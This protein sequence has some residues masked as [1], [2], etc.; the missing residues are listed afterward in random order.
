V[1]KRPGYIAISRDI[2]EH[3]L[4]KGNKPFSRLEAW[5]WLINA[6]AW[7]PQG[8]RWRF[9]ILHIERGELAASVRD[10]ANH[11]SWPKSN[12]HRFL[13]LLARESMIALTDC[14]SGTRTGTRTGTITQRAPA[15]IT[16]CNYEKFQKLASDRKRRVGHEPG[17]EPGHERQQA[18]PIPGLSASEPTNQITNSQESRSSDKARRDQKPNHGAKGRGMVWLDHGTSEWNVYANDY[19]EVRGAEKLPESR[20]GG[21]GNW[22]RLLGEQRKR[23]A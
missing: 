12:V 5:E 8:H 15:I 21:R 19:R 16:I 20:I 7:K 22:F 23:Q 3:P 9:G 6:A 1:S 10:L 4:F 11:W 2:F 17:H 14:A 13:M 18:F